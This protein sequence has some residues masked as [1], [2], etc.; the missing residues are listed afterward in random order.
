V[1]AGT[2][3]KVAVSAKLTSETAQ[4][5]DAWTGSVKD[6]VIV[7]DR[8]VIPAGS[9]VTGVVT[10]AQPAQKGSRAVLVL[11]IRSVDVNGKSHALAAGTDS[12]IAG[13]TRTRN[14]GAVAGGAAAGALIGRAIGGSGK[15]ALIGGLIGGATATG[16]VAASKGYQAEVKEG[17]E[18]SFSVNENVVMK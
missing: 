8:V 16:A 14:V 3:F 6:P 13:S 12:I 10:G 5:G 9:T 7:G 18:L 2:E 1:P 4:P 17:A 11:A 15:G